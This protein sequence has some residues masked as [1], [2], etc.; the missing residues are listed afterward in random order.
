MTE[1][2]NS[3][4]NAVLPA[5]VDVIGDELFARV[6]VNDRLESREDAYSVAAL[7]ADAVLYR[8]AVSERSDT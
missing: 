5:L 8:F 4:S 3:N 7:I 1:P 2:S 6:A